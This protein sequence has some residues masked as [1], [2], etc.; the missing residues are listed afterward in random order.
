[1]RTPAHQNAGRLGRSRQPDGKIGSAGLAL[2]GSD[3][4]APDGDRG[5][6]CSDVRVLSRYAAKLRRLKLVGDINQLSQAV[7]IQ[8]SGAQSKKEDCLLDAKEVARRL[9]FERATDAEP[10]PLIARAV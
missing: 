4:F 5:S 10:S 2:F 8:H 9:T 1:V 3:E 6:R 7:P